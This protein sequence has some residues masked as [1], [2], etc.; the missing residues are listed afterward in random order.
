MAPLQE[1]LGGYICIVFINMSA[2]FS[3][4]LKITLIIIVK[5][6][7]Q[8][9]ANKLECSEKQLNLPYLPAVVYKSEIATY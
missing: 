7:A 4:Y 6:I 5:K 9:D 3:L 1:T 2:I 8:F